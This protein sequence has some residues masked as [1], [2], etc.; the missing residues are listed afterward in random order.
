MEYPLMMGNPGDAEIAAFISAAMAYGNIKQID[1]TLRKIFSALGN[2]PV[3]AIL[4]NTKMKYLQS[5]SFGHRFYTPTD[6]QNLL[7]AL[8][9]IL[10]KY[11]SLQNFFSRNFNPLYPNVKEMLEATSSDFE[12]IVLS[13]EL[14]MT[15]GMRFIFPR[16]SGGSACKR[17][18]LFLRWMIR[19]DDIDLGIWDNIPT[20]KLIIPVDT[21]IARISRKLGL[22][23][24]KNVSWTMAEEITENLRKF[25]G[26]DPVKYDFALCHI[27]M[28]KLEF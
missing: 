2:S 26:T 1:S 12:E 23:K 5:I 17:M 13:N 28:R 20:S 4:G 14:P 3:E 9:K 15:A 11:S 8:Q 7:S 27:G 18:N 6:I 25:D 19:K 24:R 22:T 16:P 10:I 21:H